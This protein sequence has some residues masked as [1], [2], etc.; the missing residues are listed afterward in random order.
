MK[1]FNEETIMKV[2]Q[3]TDKDEV[4]WRLTDDWTHLGTIKQGDKVLHCLGK[5]LTEKEIE[6]KEEE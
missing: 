3:T 5:V 6:N 1:V 2:I 4:I